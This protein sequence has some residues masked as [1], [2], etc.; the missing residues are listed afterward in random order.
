MLP[1]HVWG[2]ARRNSVAPPSR[3]E[4]T[5]RERERERETVFVVVAVKFSA[6]HLP[7]WLA[8]FAL[9]NS[10]RCSAGRRRQRE[11]ATYRRALMWRLGIASLLSLRLLLLW[12]LLVLRQLCRSASQL[13]AQ[14]THL[15]A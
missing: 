6:V 12:L 13:A 14:Q 5:V 9:R 11:P 15:L 1:Q 7:N 10:F 3:A 4:L 8:R 2:A